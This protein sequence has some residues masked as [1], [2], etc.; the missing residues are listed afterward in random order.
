MASPAAPVLAELTSVLWKYVLAMLV[1]TALVS[2]VNKSVRK[3]VKERAEKPSLGLVPK[4]G[5]DFRQ[6]R[7]RYVVTQ[8][9]K[10]LWD[11][12]YE[13]CIHLKLVPLAQVSFPGFMETGREFN[14]VSQKRADF[15]ICNLDMEP[16]AVIELDDS[17][18]NGRKTEDDERDAIVRA[19]RI[20]VIRYERLPPR[21]Q[22]LKDLMR[23]KK[24][25]EGI[26]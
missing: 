10:R 9:E 15:L 4:I 14:R 11:V 19:A 26:E 24:Q 3:S 5:I 6:F 2:W 17:S 21:A 12:L 1:L 8:H 22:V 18:H 7:R 20:E 25:D 23:L 16:L 13:V